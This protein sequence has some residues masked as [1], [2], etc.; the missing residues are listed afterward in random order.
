MVP[1]VATY[2]SAVAFI[3]GWR[4]RITAPFHAG[5]VLWT[6]AY[7]N[8]WSMV[9]HNDNL[10][11]LHTIALAGSPAA[12]AWSLDARRV[13]TPGPSRRYGWPLQ[14]LR[15]T[16]AATYF[17][18]GMAKLR[19]PLGWRWATGESLRSQVLTDGLRKELLST[20]A[21]PVLPALL[22]QRALWRALG[23]TSL[24]IEV[25]APLALL[26]RRAGRLW[27]L[28]A[29]SMHVGI[30][31]TM[32]ITFRHQLSGVAFAPWFDVERLPAHGLRRAADRI[33]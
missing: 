16:T 13:G 2:A 21:S 10:L 17:V 6:L 27:G 5:L 24:A 28:A 29:W 9:F 1:V 8:S 15:A 26:S 22:E 30:F 11:V 33:R 25:G 20:G 4:H 7:R 23:L 19:S 3:A 18:A 31:V 12:G 14:L 32:R